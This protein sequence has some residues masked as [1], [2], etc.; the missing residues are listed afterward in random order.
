MMSSLLPMLR[1]AP[2]WMV[3]AFWVLVALG[4]ESVSVLVVE[5]LPMTRLPTPVMGPTVPLPVMVVVP[6]LTRE[7]WV[8]LAAE[9][10]TLDATVVFPLPLT[11]PAVV[12]ALM[13]RAALLVTVPPLGSAPAAP[14]ETV[15]LLMKVP[16]V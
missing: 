12:L 15:P 14:M 10:V 6:L 3:R 1:V 7:D 4:W 11:L 13:A 16:P 5:P 8:K 9:N 2:F